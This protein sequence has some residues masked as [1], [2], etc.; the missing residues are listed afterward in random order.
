MAWDAKSVS[1]YVLHRRRVVVASLGLVGALA[2]LS[3]IDLS[4]HLSSKQVFSG[5][6]AFAMLAFFGHRVFREWKLMK[7]SAR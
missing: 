1:D 5:F 4:E 6:Y 3:E 7:A 2:V